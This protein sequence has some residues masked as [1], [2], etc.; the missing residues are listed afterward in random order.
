[1]TGPTETLV[2]QNLQDCK[3]YIITTQFEHYKVEVTAECYCRS[4]E[5]LLKVKSYLKLGIP[6]VR[7]IHFYQAYC[8]LV[9]CYCY[10]ALIGGV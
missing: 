2:A 4:D 3:G 6:Y 5:K 1:M 7:L 9:V 10:V 8:T